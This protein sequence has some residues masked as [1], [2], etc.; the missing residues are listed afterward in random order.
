MTDD[1]HGFARWKAELDLERAPLT[2]AI[3]DAHPE[4]WP[5]IGSAVPA[6]WDQEIAQ[7]LQAIVALVGETGVEIRVSHIK[8]KLASFRLYLDIDEHSLGPVEITGSTPISTRLRSSSTPGSI[9]ERATGIFDAAAKRCE[10]RCER[11]GAPGAFLDDGG[12]LRIAR[13]A[14]ARRD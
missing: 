9:R 7:A 10:F 8:S 3:L 14:H 1:E 2:R 6:G 13:T 12:W 11:C 5:R 4:M